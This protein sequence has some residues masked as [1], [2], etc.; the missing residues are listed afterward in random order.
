M[1]END[2]R[3][4]AGT[5]D[6]SP[7][8]TC[9]ICPSLPTC[10]PT[11]L[12]PPP[13]SHP[14]YYLPTPMPTCSP[15]HHCASHQTICLQ[16]MDVVKQAL[17]GT[18]G[19]FSCAFFL[20]GMGRGRLFWR[21]RRARFLPFRGRMKTMNHFALHVYCAYGWNGQDGTIL[22]VC[23]WLFIRETMR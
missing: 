4:K 21:A 10:H 19:G 15:C 5:E 18:D 20:L 16:H 9:H 1:E 12:P 22:F 7:T 23:R 3:Q 17:F 14:T 6:N 8:T 2:G 11:H 13:S